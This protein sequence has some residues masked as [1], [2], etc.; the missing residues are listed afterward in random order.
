MIVID[1]VITCYLKCYFIH[2]KMRLVLQF[3]GQGHTCPN[4]QENR[5]SNNVSLS[6]EFS[7]GNIGFKLFLMANLQL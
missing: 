6:C 4:F 2:A 5:P 1:Y 3:P 7:N